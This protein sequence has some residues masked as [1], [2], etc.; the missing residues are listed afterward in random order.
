[1]E[2]CRV[3]RAL[4]SV[5]RGGTHSDLA[6][7]SFLTFLPRVAVVRLQIGSCRERPCHLG[8]RSETNMRGADRRGL[9]LNYSFTTC[10]W[11]F[12]EVVKRGYIAH[13]GTRSHVW[14]IR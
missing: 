9:L 8:A 3:K 14:Y 10:S 1:L 13:G 2:A 4:A 12:T 6:G 11:L 7:G 5:W